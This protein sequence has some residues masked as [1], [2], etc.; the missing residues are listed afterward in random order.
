[1]NGASVVYD[2]SGYQVPPSQRR[3]LAW[4]EAIEE[5]D[6]PR[7]ALE[8]E[9]LFH[10]LVRPAAA[11]LP[12]VGQVT[13]IPDGPLHRVAWAS[14]RDSATG[15]IWAATTAVAVAPC[16]SAVRE[17]PVAA[18]PLRR[19]VAV[20]NPRFDRS[21]FDLPDLPGA[22][23]EAEEVAA[24]YA[25]S[26]VLGGDAA[27]ADRVL[28][29][30]RWGDVLHIASHAVVD[31]ADGERSALIL[32]PGGR[33]APD[34]ALRAKD[35]RGGDLNRL[36]VV[37]LA[38]CRSGEGPLSRAEGPLSLARP[39]LEAGVGAVVVSLFDLPDGESAAALVHRHLRETADP[40]EAVRQAIVD[41]WDQMPGDLRACGSLQV[42]TNVQ[43]GTL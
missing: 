40:V 7:A 12:G 3:V 26:R 20:G 8:A 16:M 32:A 6:G 23:R 19:V 39:F 21:V 2:P 18:E 43:G 31:A 29:G 42:I 34:G 33:I 27:T 9:R 41:C 15:R 11:Y 30:A 22:A 28:E 38:A 17:A 1:M 25:E 37:V 24:S 14:L 35:L 36:R 5:G 13:V 10:G 4:R